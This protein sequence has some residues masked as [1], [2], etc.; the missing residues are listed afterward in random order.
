MLWQA[1]KFSSCELSQNGRWCDDD[2]EIVI[3]VVKE[4]EEEAE[5]LVGYDINSKRVKKSSSNLIWF[6]M[7]IFKIDEQLIDLLAREFFLS[8]LIHLQQCMI[9]T[10][11]FSWFYP[12][13]FELY[14]FTPQ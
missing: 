7:K 4:E 11:V 9:I 5:V 3:V 2:V 1:H 14:E 8:N 6:T 13:R 10:D 12:T